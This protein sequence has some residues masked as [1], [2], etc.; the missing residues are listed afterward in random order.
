MSSF[1]RSTSA[2]AIMIR[3]RMPPEN[4]CGYWPKRVGGMPIRPSVSSERRRASAS[5]QL[6][7]VLLERLREVLLDPHQRIQPRHRLLEDQAELG[8]AQPPQLGRRQPDEVAALVER[9]RRPRARRRGSRPRMPRPSV[10]L[11]QPDS[12]TSPSTS[13]APMSS[14]TPSTARTGGRA[15]V[16]YQTRRSRTSRTAAQSSDSP[17]RP[18]GRRLELDPAEVAPRAAPG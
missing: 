9:P 12:P 11:P 6:R 5:R 18:S 1:G 14:E 3:C 17:P 4:S 16:P 2:S 10:D 8:P 15:V 7:L 13:P